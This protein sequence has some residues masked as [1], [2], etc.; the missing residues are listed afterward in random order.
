MVQ[1]YK[2][3]RIQ[4]CRYKGA[5]VEGCICTRVQRYKGIKVQGTRVLEY[6][7]IRK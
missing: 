4:G 3:E 6:I 1:E 2:G 7:G 5:M